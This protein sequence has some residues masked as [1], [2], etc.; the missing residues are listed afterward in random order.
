MGIVP[1]RVDRHRGLIDSER[2]LG[3]ASILPATCAR[4]RGIPLDPAKERGVVNGHAAFPRE[5]PLIPIA[6]G[7]AH[8]PADRAADHL[9][10]KVA[11]CERGGVTHKRSPMV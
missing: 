5:L 7:H 6:Q 10:W 1:Q 4:L 2:I 11:A 8:V 9:T 3:G